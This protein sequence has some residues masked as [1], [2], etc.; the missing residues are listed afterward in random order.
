MNVEQLLSALPPEIFEMVKRALTRSMAR[1]TSRLVSPIKLI[2][3]IVHHGSKSR[4]YEFGLRPSLVK[5]VLTTLRRKSFQR[6][7]MNVLGRLYKR[8]METFHPFA[9]ERCNMSPSLVKEWIR[10]SEQYSAISGESYLYELVLFEVILKEMLEECT[11]DDNYKNNMQ[12]FL[13]L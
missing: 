2:A 12:Q 3:N 1:R 5:K 4:I 7:E 9:V 13:N 11:H 6:A 8:C 10:A